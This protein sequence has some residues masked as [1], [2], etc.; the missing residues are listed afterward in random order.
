M[1]KILSL[2]EDEV[3]KDKFEKVYLEMVAF[4]ANVN[5]TP[6]RSNSSYEQIVD[7]IE[8]GEYIYSSFLYAYNI[9]L[10]KANMHWWVFKALFDGLPDDSKIKQIMGFRG[11][12]QSKKKSETIYKEL[13]SA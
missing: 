1:L 9:D 6:K 3:P 5:S 12:K 8:D 7:F 13:K 10:L 11:Y 4:Y 2:L